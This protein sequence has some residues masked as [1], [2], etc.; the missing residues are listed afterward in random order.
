[1][2]VAPLEPDK[3]PWVLDGSAA[4]QRGGFAK[5]FAFDLSPL[6]SEA[7]GGKVTSSWAPL[8]GEKARQLGPFILPT[9]SGLA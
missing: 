9:A 1:M 7:L 6:I 5:G 2:S 3:W 4:G 8:S